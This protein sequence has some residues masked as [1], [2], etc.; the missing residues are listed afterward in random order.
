MPSV[1]C[2][3]PRDSWVLRVRWTSHCRFRI[4]PSCR[5]W[6]PSRARRRRLRLG[7]VYAVPERLNRPRRSLSRPY[8]EY[9]STRLPGN[10]PSPPQRGLA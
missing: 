7:P 4:L 1:T 3:D 5:S 6:S 2:L 8:V 9:P 10:A